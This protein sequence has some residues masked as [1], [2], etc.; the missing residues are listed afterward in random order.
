MWGGNDGRIELE[1]DEDIA[2]S[3]N[4][5]TLVDKV[6]SEKVVN[7]S[8]VHSIVQRLWNPQFGVTVMELE[9]NIYLFKFKKKED[10]QRTWTRGPWSIMGNHIVLNKWYANAKVSDIDFSCSWF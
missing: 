8:D 10:I 9:D 4:N 3:L 2:F 5:L 6:V 7:K 1:E